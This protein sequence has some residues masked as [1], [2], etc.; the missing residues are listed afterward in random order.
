MTTNLQRFTQIHFKDHGHM[1]SIFQVFSKYI[2]SMMCAY[3]NL[4]FCW[5]KKTYKNAEFHTFPF[6][7]LISNI[8]SDS[9]YQKYE[10]LWI[11]RWENFW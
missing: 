8:I 11:Y 5:Y 1:G 4:V 7:I 2:F 9:T 6:W 10:I 3:G